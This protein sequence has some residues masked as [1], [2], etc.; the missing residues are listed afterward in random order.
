MR[1]HKSF[2]LLA[3][4]LFTTKATAT[5]MFSAADLTNPYGAPVQSDALFVDEDPSGASWVANA[6]I[7]ELQGLAQTTTA[8]SADGTL[9]YSIGGGVGGSLI[10]TNV[11]RV[12]NTVTDTWST[13]APIP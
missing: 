10:P 5:G 12:Y 6:P 9:I 7:P 4:A 1:L 2:M 11:V 3:V 13:A 8:P